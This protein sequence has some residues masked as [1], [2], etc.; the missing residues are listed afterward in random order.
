MDREKEEMERLLEED[1]KRRFGEDYKG[2]EK[3]EKGLKEELEELYGKM[4]KIY[5]MGQV[6]QLKTCLK[7]LSV[8]AKNLVEQ[9]LEEKFH[10]INGNNAN[11]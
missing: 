7:T 4:Y 1:K 3:V 8:Y 5:R 11:F 2:N 9:P 6:A 10:K